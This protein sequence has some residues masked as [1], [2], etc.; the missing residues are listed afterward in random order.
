M[1]LPTS[2]CKGCRVRVQAPCLLS[3]FTV[4]AEHIIYTSLVMAR[5]RVV[6]KR[7]SMLGLELYDALV[8]A[9]LVKLR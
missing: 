9:Q 6:S 7:Q 8:G 4:S 5:S 2:I 3:H 1:P